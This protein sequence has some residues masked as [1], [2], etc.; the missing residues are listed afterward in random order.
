MRYNFRL[1]IIIIPGSTTLVSRVPFATPELIEGLVLGAISLQQPELWVKTKHGCECEIQDI[2]EAV[3]KLLFIESSRR[4]GTR[5]H[6]DIS[7]GVMAMKA[8]RPKRTKTK[9]RKRTA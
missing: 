9:R 8:K 5:I 4:Q 7:R 6:V 2:L 1:T 3:R